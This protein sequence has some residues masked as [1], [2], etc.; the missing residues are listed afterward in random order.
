VKAI[1]KADAPAKDTAHKN[2]KL[3]KAYQHL[4]ANAREKTAQRIAQCRAEMP[5]LYRK[6]YDRVMFGEASP[7]EAIKMQCLECYG[8]TRTETQKCN[9]YLCPLYHHR[10]YKKPVK[11]PTERL[12]QPRIDKHRTKDS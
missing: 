9:N 12:E 1:E 2:I 7:R 10:P 6:L 8:H 5:K 4:P 11:L 3:P